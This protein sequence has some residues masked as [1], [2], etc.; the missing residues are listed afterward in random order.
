[1]NDDEQVA[2]R[3]LQSK[4][5]QSE[6]NN[7]KL[8]QAVTIMQNKNEDNLIKYQLEIEQTLLRIERLLRKQVPKRDPV[9]K[10]VFYVDCPKNQL[11]NEKGVNEI[12]NLL[13]WYV[14]KE[15]ILSC[16]TDKQID[17]IMSQF[18]D[19]LAD[20]LY[21]NLEDFGLDTDEKQKH[22]PMIWMNIV[23]IVDATY[24]KAVDGKTLDN[25]KTARVVSQTEPLG[26]H[27]M[28]PSVNKNSFKLLNPRT[29]RG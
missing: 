27:P 22:Y 18:G 10:N 24:R 25:I 28:Y 21:T 11:L 29:W 14:N 7:S 23:N 19:E 13:S 9:T 20:F 4:M 2:Y 15:I 26:N 6:A 5:A 8:V 17:K 12:M 16:Y 1:M 3:N